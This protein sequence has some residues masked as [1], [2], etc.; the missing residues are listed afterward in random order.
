MSNLAEAMEKYL[1]MG[2]RMGLDGPEL[3]AF[4]DKQQEVEKTRL[5]E[6]RDER[7]AA[8]TKEKEKSDHE[9]A[10]AHEQQA[11]VKAKQEQE[12]ALAKARQEQENALAK[13]R[14]DQELALA[15]A[16]QDQEITRVQEQHVLAQE[17]HALAKAK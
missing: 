11:L 10:L 9:I 7:A 17:Q 16:K 6:E 4:L 15:K 2:E 12:N 5:N 13:A 8:R 14:Q 1:A 3:K